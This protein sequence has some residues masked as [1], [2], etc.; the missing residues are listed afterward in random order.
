[1]AWRFKVSKYKNAAPKFLRKE[2]NILD[3]PVSD[4]AQSCGNHIKSSCVYFAFNIDSGGGG[5]LGFLPLS[6]SGRQGGSLPILQA[7]GDVVTDFDFSPFDDYLLATGAQDNKV[8]LWLLPEEESIENV[9]EAVLSLPAYERR[10]ENVL[11]NPCADGVLAVTTD[12]SVKIYDISGSGGSEIFSF[13]DHGDQVQGVSWHGDGGLLVTTCK[14][15]KIRVIDPRSNSV[16]QEGAGHPNVKDSRVLW[17]A[18]KE[19]IL[20][21]GF[22]QTR[23]RQFRIWDPRNLSSSLM[24]TDID[25]ST[26]TIMP[27]YDADTNMTFLIGKGDNSLNFLEFT[28]K[29]PYLSSAGVDRTEQIKGAALVPKRAMNLMDGEVNRVLLLCKNSVI[30]APYIVPRKSY[31]DFH[32][33]LYPDT[34]DGLPAQTSDQWA[35]GQAAQPNFI[36][37]EPCKHLVHRDR[38]GALLKGS[39]SGTA[40]SSSAVKPQATESARN[41]SV[42][43]PSK[44]PPAVSSP[45][46][47]PEQPSN[48][49]QS[50][51]SPSPKPQPQKPQQQPKQEPIPAKPEKP[52]EKPALPPK[53]PA[54]PFAGVRQSKFRHIQGHQQ[55][56]SGSITNVR[57]VCKTVPGESDMFAANVKRCAVPVDG[58]GGCL[59]VFELS[60][61]ARQ[62]DTGVP[63]IQNGSK[64]TDCAWDPFDDSR[65]VVVLDNAKIN[66]WRIPDGGLTESTDEPEFSLRGHMEK[67]YFVKFH[68]LASDLIITAAYDMTL[69]M[70]DLK[71]QKEVMLIEGHDDQVFCLD[72]SSDGK[73]FATVSKDGKVRVFEPRKSTSALREGPGPVGSRGARIVW[74]LNDKFLVVTGFDRTSLQQVY[75]YRASELKVLHSVDVNV[76]PAILMPFYDRD[77]SVVFLTCRGD[78]MIYTLEVAEDAPHLFECAP[79]K[80]DSLHQSASYLPKYTCD[81]RKVEVMR[82][83]RLTSNSV[84]G[85]TFTVPRVKMEYFQD[86]LFPNT[87]VTW[88][89][90]ITAADWLAGKDKRQKTKSLRPSDMKPLS[91]A[92]VEAPK[93]KKF[94]SYNAETYK[95]DEQRK[96][97]LVS[98]MAGK[99]EMSDAPLPQDLAEGVDDDEWDD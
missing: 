91:E 15:K 7:H 31:R 27:L 52:A 22:S 88:E 26:G 30:P 69:R 57:S 12:K 59:Y 94:E 72:W 78:R 76:S 86:D 48:T 85:F 81:V 71:E 56:A 82:G 83:W 68:P 18:G 16:V 54:K 66:V 63:V 32:S 73:Q 60:E 4:V 2:E 49:S 33:D 19:F 29:D 41:D 11:W 39:N 21:T 46:P 70:W 14:D 89:P 61:G 25:T 34:R 10:V 40:V 42:T 9:S 45:P 36:K 6:A 28:E 87:D 20:S 13:S 98:A 51:S 79:F 93:A 67:I 99:L 5:N 37:L 90:T 44:P 58:A 1:M 53:K 55:H 8:K 77:S 62:P 35:Q 17:L 96:E 74:A 24:S 84:D 43:Q 3:I 80:F 95:T 65:L 97:E 92:P 50:N 38:R 23:S 75:I 64:V 47:A